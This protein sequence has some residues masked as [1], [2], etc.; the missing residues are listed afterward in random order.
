MA[1]CGGMGDGSTLPVIDYP[2]WAAGR[3][4]LLGELHF[5]G[6]V[7][8]LC[9]RCGH[10][11]KPS[12][13]PRSSCPQRTPLRR[14]FDPVGHYHRPDIF[15]LNVDTQSRPAVRSSELVD[16]RNQQRPLSQRAVQDL[17]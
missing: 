1:P 11:V 10:L 12:S 16:I 15:H 14:Y 8:P 9:P 13:P 7:P 4:D 2:V 3:T 5:A 6:P 17:D